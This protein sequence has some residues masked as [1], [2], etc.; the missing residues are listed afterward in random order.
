MKA[1][2]FIAMG[3]I[4]AFLS[5]A[6]GA[7]AAHSLKNMLSSDM[8]TVFHTA[9]DYQMWHGLGLLIIGLLLERKPSSLLI[10]SGWSML[11]GIVLFSGSLY[12][13]ALTGVKTFG[14]ITPFGGIAFLIAWAMLAY[15]SIKQ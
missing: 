1:S 9:V 7:F 13:L 6:L 5:V 4:I 14:A 3:A 11:I 15:H 10:K 8:L 2:P 12:I